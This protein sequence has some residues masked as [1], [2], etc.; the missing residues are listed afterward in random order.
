MVARPDGALLCRGVAE[1]RK[2][3]QKLG[4]ADVATQSQTISGFLAEQLGDVPFAGAEIDIRGFKFVVTKASN[5]R[6]ERIR[7]TPLEPV[8]P[9]ADAQSAG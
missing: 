8:E 3:F 2:V 5:R 1:A 9:A 4:L 6:A 7:I